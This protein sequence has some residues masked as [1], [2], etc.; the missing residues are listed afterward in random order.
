MITSAIVLRYGLGILCSAKESR[1]RRWAVAGS[2][3]STSGNLRKIVY[4]M[5]IYIYMYVYMYI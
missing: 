4:V 2:S 1:T 5:C 3:G